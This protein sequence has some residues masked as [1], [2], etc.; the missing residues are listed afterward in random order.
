MSPIDVRQFLN[1]F[2]FSQA[3]PNPADPR[4]SG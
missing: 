2:S 4:Y 1:P 3:S